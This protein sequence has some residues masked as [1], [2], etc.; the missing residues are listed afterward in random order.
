[1]LPM[2]YRDYG[3]YGINTSFTRAVY[4]LDDGDFVFFEYQQLD[5]V[6]A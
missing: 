1:M 5:K 4:I 6:Y 2:Y 3:D